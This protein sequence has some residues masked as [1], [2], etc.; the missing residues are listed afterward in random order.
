MLR[1]VQVIGQVVVE[2]GADVP[3]DRLQLDEDQ[4]QAVD[5]ADEV[6]AAVVVRHA[7]ALHLQLAHGQEAVVGSRGSRKSITCACACRVSPLR[8]ATPPARRR[9]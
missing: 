2:A 6:G 8:R 4:R 7:H 9:G 5:E 1:S 3:I